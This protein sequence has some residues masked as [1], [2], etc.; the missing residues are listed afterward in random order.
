MQKKLFKIICGHVLLL[1]EEV[2]IQDRHSHSDI[3]MVIF[4]NSSKQVR[5]HVRQ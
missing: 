1:H 2:L 4:Q 3:I 5:L